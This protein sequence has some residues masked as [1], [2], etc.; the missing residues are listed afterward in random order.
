MA[1]TFS[2]VA[3]GTFPVAPMR[4]QT[5]T[6][7][8]SFD[9]R[10]IFMALLLLASLDLLRAA[11]QERVADPND[12][13]RFPPVDAKNALN[14][15]QI[16]KGFR[17]ETVASE[18]LVVDPIALAF[19]E[20]GRLFVAEMNDYPDRKQHL[21]QI[22]RLEDSDGDVSREH[23]ILKECSEVWPGGWITGF[24]GWSIVTQAT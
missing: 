22:R 12:L 1:L 16:R 5:S 14:T 19:D 23:W 7:L 3:A 13:P 6:W 15:F 20:D 2:G 8:L 24:M 4:M 21:G 17:L 18:P 11:G 9:R 10:A